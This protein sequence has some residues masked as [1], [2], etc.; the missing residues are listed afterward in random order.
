[1]CWTILPS[2]HTTSLFGFDIKAART[3]VLALPWVKEASVR[4][5]YPDTLLVDI[6]EHAPFARMLQRGR[7]HLVTVDGEGNHQ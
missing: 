7:I 4:R 2:R 1:M 3:R 5:V 6:E